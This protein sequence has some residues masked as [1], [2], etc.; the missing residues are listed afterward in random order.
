MRGA[1][2]NTLWV[3]AAAVL[4]L[5]GGSAP[6]A[7]DTATGTTPAAT[8]SAVL[9]EL[10]QDVGGRGAT[11]HPERYGYLHRLDSHLQ[12]VAASRLGGG[13]A[14]SAREAAEQ[15]G[16]TTSRAGDVA[17]DVYVEGD[18]PAAAAALRA[19]GMLVSATSDDPPQRMVEGLVAPA[20]LPAVA[21]LPATHAVVAPF[22][23]LSTGTTLSQGDAA[24]HAPAARAFGP[25]GQG[26]TV[27]VISDS[28]NQVGG[29]VAASQATGDLPAVVTVLSDGAGGTD[30]GRAMAE[31]VYDEAPGIAGITF[32]TANGGPAAKAAA[33]DAMVSRGVKV[34]ADDTSYIS[35]P[36][37]QD[38]VVAQAVDRARAAGVAVFVAAGNNASQSWQGAYSGGAS[39][40]FDPGPATDTV[41]TVGT[42]RSGETATIVLQWAEPWGHAT[43]DFAL[44]LYRI[45][46]G[47][48]TFE[49]TVDTNN[50]T[51]GL[52]E[53]VAQITGSPRTYGIAI[54][55]R[56]GTGTPLLKFI[57]FTGNTAGVAIEH[58]A[59]A[60][61]ISPDAASAKGALTVAA[62]YWSTPTTP[63]A[64]S[65]RGPVATYFT[66]AG[67]A[68]ATP[69]VRAKPELAAPDGVST[70]VGS[71]FR[72]FYGTSAA[73][74]AAAGIAALLFSARP[75][76]SVDVL[77]GIMTNP[78]NALAC[79]ATG[80]ACGSGFLLADEAV[81]MALDAAPPVVTP[82]LSPATPDG[83]NGWY[84]SPVTVTWGIDDGDSPVTLSSG[85]GPAA[86]GDAVTATLVCVASSAGGTTT[87][88]VTLRRDST[89]PTPPVIGGIAPRTYTTATVPR[90][91]GIACQ[92]TD[93]TSGVERCT[94]TGYGAGAGRHRLT[95]VAVDDAGLTSTSTLAY[96]VVE[97]AAISRLV[98]AKGL[99]IERLRRSGAALS[100]RTAS[101]RTRL[102]V[103]LL[104]RVGQR[105]IALGHITKRVQRGTSGVRVSITPSARRR[106]AAVAKA[107]VEVTVTGSATGARRTTLHARRVSG[108]R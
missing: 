14:S 67:A 18:V 80:N 96:S 15:Q 79:G 90:A 59:F 101:A 103:S 89:P 81:G 9:G 17:V 16:V 68:L 7:A 76:I 86:P 84:R 45:S 26:V 49:R 60:G 104:A 64:F 98:L 42:L 6:A 47:S 20:A 87:G 43:D 106:L 13:S 70:S 94:V 55:R 99:T 34:I 30:E 74:P 46:G 63:E 61:A 38:D 32:A 21:A 50:I 69:E 88:T 82:T 11:A 35:E 95:A 105:T 28:I 73:T 40:D 4:A 51:S 71:S 53:E 1:T 37:F 8:P 75:Q 25:T 97:P 78:A 108:H 65:S 3:L 44:D 85:C 100:V 29:G 62:S 92:A 31:I 58:P 107:M 12:A 56:S 24:I 36:F 66:T 10:V 39:E 33:I 91:G 48:P 83:D 2:R 19:L 52:P 54:R 41:Q 72:P 27:G 5:A 57:D 93:A 23:Q 77:A 22:A 102:V